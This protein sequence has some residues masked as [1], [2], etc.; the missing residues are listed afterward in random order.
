MLSCDIQR[1]WCGTTVGRKWVVELRQRYT[2]GEWSG[3]TYGWGRHK[4]KKTAIIKARV[5]L[6]NSQATIREGWNP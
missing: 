4:D 2:Y 1:V 3:M 6:R 5:D